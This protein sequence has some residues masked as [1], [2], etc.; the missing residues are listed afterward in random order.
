MLA[1]AASVVMSSQLNRFYEIFGRKKALFV[2]TAICIACQV[3]IAFLT[4]NSAWVIYVLSF[5]VGIFCFI[6]VRRNL[7]CW[8]LEST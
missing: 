4:A 8:L 5:F 3:A 6:K 2:G 1:Y 7:W